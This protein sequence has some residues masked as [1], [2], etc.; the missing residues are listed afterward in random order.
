MGAEIPETCEA[1][2]FPPQT[3][4]GES[5]ETLIKQGEE[6]RV[7]HVKRVIGGI[8]SARQQAYDSPRAISFKSQAEADYKR[9]CL[10]RVP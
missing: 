1:V 7:G 2:T 4:C 3:V 8:Y 6:K 10:L 5:N 9:L